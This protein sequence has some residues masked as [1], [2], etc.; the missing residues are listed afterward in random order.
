YALMRDYAD[1]IQLELQRVADVG[2]V[3]LLGLQDEKI[4]IELSNTKLATLGISLQQVQQA[5]AQQNAIAPAS[6]FETPSDRV[7]LRVTGQFDSVE[8]I[9]QFPIRAG[10][11]TIHLGDIAQVKRGFA[12]P[13]STK[14]R[15][16]GEDAI[17]I[18]V[19]MKQ[20]GDILKLGETLDAEFER[21]QKTLPAGMQLRKVS[22][23]PHAVEESVG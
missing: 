14:M 18:A 2:K 6:F 19:A 12:D 1:R 8:A 20:G 13:A 17:G 11:R 21:L 10:D 3:D 23:Q 16:M 4:W 15:F 22:D 5:L 7:Q 9:E